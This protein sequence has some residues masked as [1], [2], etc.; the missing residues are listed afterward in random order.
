MINLIEA[1]FGVIISATIDT[2]EDKTE[3][4]KL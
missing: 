4:N 1:K 2:T 3:M